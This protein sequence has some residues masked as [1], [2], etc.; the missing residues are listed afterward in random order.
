[1]SDAGEMNVLLVGGGGREHAL[2]WGLARSP[3][4]RRLDIAPGSAAMADLGRCVDIAAHDVPALVSLAERERYDL[5]VVGP[6][7]PLVQGLC[8]RLAERG[9]AV[10]GPR[11]GA[12]ELEGSKVF[13]KRFMTRHD[14]PT[15]DYVVFDQA[16][17]ATRWLREGGRVFPLVIKADGLAAGKGVVIAD[18]AAAAADAAEG[19]LSGRAFGEAGR[20][21]VIE[22]RL[23]GREVSFFVLASGTDFVELATCQDY[24]R[25]EDA[26]RGPNTGGMGAYSPSVLDPETREEIVERIVRP[27]LAGLVRDE[28][29]YC[30]AL[31]IGLMLTP[32]GP[33]VLEYNVRFGDPETQVLVPRF[34]S[35]GGDW[36]DVLHRAATGRL[37][38]ATLS[39]ARE[40]AVCVVMTSAGYP[41]PYEAGAQI[42]GLER[43]A[44]LDDVLVF[45]A[46]TRRDGSGRWVTAGGRVLAVTALGRDLADARSR[47]YTAV[48]RIDWSGERH[49]SDIARI[50]DSNLISRGAK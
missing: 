7:A 39:F 44:E 4:A 29:P 1:V 38:G 11:A 35:G 34:V 2:A 6:E 33:R 15:A 13:A 18:D 23:V 16:P 25:A 43:A 37:G 42:N 47:A 21:V 12:A 24:K 14:I 5:V 40:A 46:G 30:G 49:R 45:H 8:D 20:R 26:D 22:E 48:D 41:G 32:A 36:V 9:I 50:G 27:T 31:Y 28:R 3:R 19:M 17:A 10:F